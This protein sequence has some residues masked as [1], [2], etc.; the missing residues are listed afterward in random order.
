[1]ENELRTTG[2]QV[3]LC[4][5]E[6]TKEGKIFKVGTECETRLRETKW[7]EGGGEVNNL[8]KKYFMSNMTMVILH[9]DK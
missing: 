6:E 1:V 2:Y 7:G 9:I 3:K 5:G 8:F 4:E